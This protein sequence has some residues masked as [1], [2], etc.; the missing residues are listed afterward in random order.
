MQLGGINLVDYD[1]W[2]GNFTGVLVE[3]NQIL[4][5]FATN[6][7]DPSKQ[8]GKNANETFIK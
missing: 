8:E 5:G 2:S 4:G 1:P 6:L 7:T 3:D